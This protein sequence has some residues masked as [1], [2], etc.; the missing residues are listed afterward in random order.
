MDV[1]DDLTVASRASH[2]A[3]PP[4]R[5]GTFATGDLVGGRYRIVGMLGRGGMGE[6]YRADDLT[7]GQTVALKFLP[8]SVERNPEQLERLR[9]EVRITRQVSHPNVCRVYDLGSIASYEWRS[10]AT[11]S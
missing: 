10:D 5:D 6:V 2:P 11:R 8:R 9:A 7:L 1:P 4:G 3:T